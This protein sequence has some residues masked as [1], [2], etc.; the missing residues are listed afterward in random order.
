MYSTKWS[1]KQTIRHSIR[2]LG[3]G[4]DTLEILKAHQQQPICKQVAMD[5]NT[6]K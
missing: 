4:S 2:S 3:S 6:S 5:R 1:Y